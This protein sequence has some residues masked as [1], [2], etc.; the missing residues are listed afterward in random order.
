MIHEIPYHDH[1]TQAAKHSLLKL[2]LT[3][4]EI[5]FLQADTVCNKGFQMVDATAFC[6]SMGYS[7]ALSA[8]SAE[9][10]GIEPHAIQLTYDIM[11]SNVE[12]EEGAFN[13]T[14][15]NYDLVHDCEHTNDVYLT[16]GG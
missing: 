8:S 10:Q 2:Y 6:K 16:C 4:T 12:C 7:C 3:L 15:C 14:Q 5:K 13:L 1:L 9:Q 11:M